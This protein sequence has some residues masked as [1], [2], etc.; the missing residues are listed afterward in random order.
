MTGAIHA[1]DKTTGAS[2]WKQDKLAA[3]FPSGPAVIGDYLGVVDAE[4][5]LHLLDRND[6]SLVGRVATDGSRRDIATANQRRR[7]RLAER[8]RQPDQRVGEVSARCNAGVPRTPPPRPALYPY[9]ATPHPNHATHPRHRRP[10]QRRQIDA[11]QPADAI[12]RRARRRLSRAD[13][14]SP[15]RPR[16]WRRPT[17]SRRRHGRLRA[18]GDVGHHARDGQ[19]DAHRDRG[20]RRGHLPGR[21]PRRADARRTRSSPTCCAARADRCCSRST[22]PK[23]SRP[24]ASRPNSTSSRS[25]RRCRSR[26]RTARTSA[27]WSTPRWRCVRRRRPTNPRRAE[28][29]A[30][31]IKVAIVGRPNVGKSTLI[32]TLLGEE[33]V[34]AFDRAG[35]DA[36]FA[37]SR[38]RSRRTPLHAHRHRGRAQARQGHRC[39][40]EILGHQDAAGDRGRQRRDPAGR[41]A[42]GHF[43]TGRAHRRLHPRSRSCA[44]DRRQQVGRSGEGRARTRQ[45][46]TRAASL[47]SCPSPSCI[48]S[49][50]AT[51][52]ASARC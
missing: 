14:R 36:R 35:H 45:A 39:H 24:S 20:S 16:T 3:R 11:V 15:L 43:G 40:R 44:D 29:D 25:A 13:A 7:D 51:A 48:R 1:L 46:R 38:F 47:P 5:Y 23:G 19:A 18:E 42:G 8:R 9:P 49:R 50:R 31:R 17:V 34:I 30:R 52:R 33:R 41:R 12:A 6:G 37:V 10:S 2:A 27:T 32:N 26:R 28:D 4:G 22:R 21:R